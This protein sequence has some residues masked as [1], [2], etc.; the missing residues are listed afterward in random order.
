MPFQRWII[1]L[2][3]LKRL[4]DDVSSQLNVKCNNEGQ[5]TC[6]AGPN[7]A[8]EDLRALGDGLVCYF[9]RPCGWISLWF[10]LT[11]CQLQVFEFCVVFTVSLCFYWALLCEEAAHLLWS[12][13]KNSYISLLWPL[14][15]GVTLSLIMERY[16]GCVDPTLEKNDCNFYSSQVCWCWGARLRLNRRGLHAQQ[17]NL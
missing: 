2:K 17:L 16:P 7:R 3:A 12:R 4:D 14:S 5:L 11:P 1:A 9:T 13:A 6:K 10:L 15:P 8:T